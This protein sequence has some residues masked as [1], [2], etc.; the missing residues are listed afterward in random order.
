MKKIIIVSNDI[1][2][3]KQII[4]NINK[5][6]NIKFSSINIYNIQ[7]LKENL[8]MSHKNTI[9]FI[10]IYG[11]ENEC[12]DIIKKI[13]TI[14]PNNKI[15]LI[16]LNNNFKNLL[17]SQTSIDAYIEKG[18][19]FIK[20]L[21]EI[22]SKIENINSNKINISTTDIPITLNKKT[23]ENIY[24]F[25]SKKTLIN[26]Q[27]GQNSILISTTK[28]TKELQ[29]LTNHQFYTPKS[30]IPTK[31][32]NYYSESLKQL[33][34]DLHIKYHIDYQTLSK[35]FNIEQKYIKK[36]SSLTKYNKKRTLLDIII[37][38]LII[39]SYFKK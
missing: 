12:L 28:T 11:I 15:V 34:V 23:I 14:K 6:K 13:K 22:L 1:C 35:H 16:D 4:N 24:N 39:K 37:G 18:A 32:R 3:T 25:P 20:Q 27:N 29:K 21:T 2:I 38:H 36:W 7:E 9:Y 26:Y 33:L 19:N 17:T 10:D 31:K 5:L 8:K 30:E